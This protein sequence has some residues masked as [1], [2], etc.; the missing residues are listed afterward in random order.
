MLKKQ[1]LFIDTDVYTDR[2]CCM[3]PMAHAETRII[4][5]SA[6]LDSP[7]YQIAL[8]LADAIETGTDGSI[9]IVVETSQGAVENVKESAAY[10]EDYLFTT[11][12]SLIDQ[13]VAGE[14]PFE[15]SEHY[16]DIRSLFPLPSY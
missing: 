16:A 14:D 5:K 7:Y 11:P 15:P 12:P 9:M 13:A 3:C 10:G 8:Q 2:V 1:I 4:Y 6:Q